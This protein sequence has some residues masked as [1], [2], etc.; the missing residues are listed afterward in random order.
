MPLTVVTRETPQ[1]IPLTEIP[2]FDSQSMLDTSEEIEKLRGM[3][4]D[5]LVGPITVCP[6]FLGNIKVPADA[7]AVKNNATATITSAA[8]IFLASFHLE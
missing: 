5:E 7:C 2:G 4:I 3:E 1:S 6:A 8:M